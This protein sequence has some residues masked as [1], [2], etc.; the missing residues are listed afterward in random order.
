M[1]LYEYGV[2]NSYVRDAV[3]KGNET[4]PYLSKEWENVYYF[5]IR[6]SSKE[7]ARKKAEAKYSPITGF[8]IESLEKVNE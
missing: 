5:T 7:M 8:I 1:N 4:P 2:Y 6:A 3:R